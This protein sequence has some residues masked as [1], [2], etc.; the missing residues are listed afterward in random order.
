METKDMVRRGET[1]PVKESRA[2]GTKKYKKIECR[3]RL[4][5]NKE[6][7]TWL[8][9]SLGGNQIDLLQHTLML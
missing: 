5:M 7:L 1:E 4:A 9:L 8:E 2:K 3:P 6:L